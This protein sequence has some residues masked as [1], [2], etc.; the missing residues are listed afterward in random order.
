[1]AQYD[2]NWRLVKES[3]NPLIEI[4]ASQGSEIENSLTFRY[5]GTWIEVF[6]RKQEFA[7][8]SVDPIGNCQN[9][10]SQ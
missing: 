4:R 7:S 6:K 10:L 3:T 9:W 2:A 8:F 1:M 5:L